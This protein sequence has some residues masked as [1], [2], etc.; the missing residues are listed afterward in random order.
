MDEWPDDA[1][2]LEKVEPAGTNL[3]GSPPDPATYV[4]PLNVFVE[5]HG[6][7]EAYNR[8][9]QTKSDYDA[10]V[11][12]IIPEAQFTEPR[13]NVRQPAIPP[14]PP[15]GRAEPPETDGQPISP[16]RAVAFDASKYVID[17]GIKTRIQGR[18]RKV[19]P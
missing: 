16:G 18:Y 4:G 19:N 15:L 6:T 2:P 10:L 8:A 5:L 13:L 12:P 3:R 11:P 17:T 1:P 14:R 9:A 7:A